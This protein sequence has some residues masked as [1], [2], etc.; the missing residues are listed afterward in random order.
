MKNF[1]ALQ[2]FL[3]FCTALTF[4][5]FSHISFY[6]NIGV[7][8]WNFRFFAI[9]LARLRHIHCFRTK[10]IVGWLIDQVQEISEMIVDGKSQD[11]SFCNIGYST[12][13][14]QFRNDHCWTF[15]KFLSEILKSRF[16][17]GLDFT[18]VYYVL[19]F[20]SS[21]SL[22]LLILAER[23]KFLRDVNLESIWI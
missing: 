4:V 19:C 7:V 13:I 21:V 5:L 10:R 20:P 23:D 1:Q 14:L 15:D 17:E 18:S 9:L 11:I 12:D 16:A 3:R 8:C 6:L 2:Y 22:G